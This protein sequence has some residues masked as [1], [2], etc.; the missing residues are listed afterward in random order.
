VTL[1]NRDKVLLLAVGAIVLILGVWWLLIRPVQAEA[2]DRE[3]QLAQIE[4][5]NADLR[6]ELERLAAEPESAEQRAAERL[7]LAKA[8]PAG[9]DTAGAVVQ[10]QEI[11]RQTNVTF[12]AVRTESRTS[13]GALTGTEYEVEVTGRFF[14][15]DDF[16]FRVHRQVSVDAQDEP[17]VGGRLFATTG[18][19][20]SL[21][22]LES[23]TGSQLEPTDTV[24][25]TVIVVAFD[26][27]DGVVLPEETEAAADDAGEGSQGDGGEEEGGAETTPDPP[28]PAG[29]EQTT[30]Q[31]DR[32]GG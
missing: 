8:V 9:E 11:A 7:R 31:P 20:M 10:L 24:R 23:G 21:A 32:S 15:V 18:V 22:E 13:Y 19:D 1:S 17:E 29:D 25:A 26:E 28:A 4:D 30:A 27:G 16:L 6:D 12:R 2:S 3:E 14:N 5:D